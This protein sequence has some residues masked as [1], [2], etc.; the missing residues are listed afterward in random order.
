[1]S[2]IKN[3]KKKLTIQ[4]I[5]KSKNSKKLTMITAYDA[6]F[7]KLFDGIVDMILVG[8]SLN[9]SFS[10]NQDTLKLSLKNMIYH[11][12]A[13]C[14]GAP[15]SFVI[16][17]MPFGTYR[18]KKQALKNA[19][20]VYKKTNANAIKIEGGK[21]KV[22]IIKYLTQNSISVMGH[23]GLMPQNIRSEGSYQIKGKLKKEEDKLIKD[24]IELEKAGVFCIV[25]EAVKSEVTKKITEAINIP[26]IG[27]GSGSKTDGQVL[28]Y[29]DMLGLNIDFKPKFVKEYFNGAFLIKEAIK[30]YKKEIEEEI[31]PSKD[32]E[33]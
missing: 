19:I 10:N 17:D 14:S 11:T 30:K 3:D 31:F 32:E 22:K 23:I 6:V 15:N 20:K 9:M 4:N 13:V 7:A 16:L 29:T 18:N 25:V 26:V 12:Q 28:V 5:I 24:A 8:D 2:M 33:Y 27:I 1:M 21:N